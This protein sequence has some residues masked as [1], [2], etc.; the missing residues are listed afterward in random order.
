MNDDWSAFGL[1]Y[2]GNT[3]TNLAIKGL[4]TR[5]TDAEVNAALEDG[6]AAADWGKTLVEKADEYYKYL[7][8]DYDYVKAPLHYWPFTPNVLSNGGFTNGY[9]FKNE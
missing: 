2:K 4:F 6:Y 1:D 5:L 8:Y 3:N 9:G 7:F